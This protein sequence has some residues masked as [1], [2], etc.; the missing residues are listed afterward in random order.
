MFHDSDLSEEQTMIRRFVTQLA[1]TYTN[2]Y[3]LEHSRDVQFPATF[4]TT[5]AD[6]GFFGL[7]AS[8]AAGGSGFGPAELAVFLHDMAAAGLASYHLLGQLLA[9]HLLHAHGS[10]AQRQTQLAQLVAGVRWGVAMVDDPRGRSLDAASVTATNA[11]ADVRLSGRLAFVPCAPDL[12]AL[13]VPATADGEPALY[14]L[15]PK[16][17]GVEATQR[18]ISVRVIE[19]REPQRITGDVFYDLELKQVA[20][21]PLGKA[22]AEAYA[23]A[24][25]RSLLM[26]AATASGWGARAIDQGVAYAN[27]RILYT[28]PIAAYQAIQHP[29]VRAK[30]QVEMAN[31]LIER[32]VQAWI[33]A[34]DP[35]TCQTYAAVAKY[36]AVEGAVA[37]FDIAMQ[38][39][40]GS[41]F[42][43]ETGLI[44]VW[45][46]VLM[47]R[48]MLLNR[49]VVLEDLGRQ[50]L[51]AG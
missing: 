5:L 34:A 17:A 49:D 40:G 1:R 12:D 19:A 26:L 27:E 15:D 10:N 33:D 23:G 37:A 44:T 6:N 21:E 9:A 4:W 42:D 16:A 46:L 7:E 2:D 31:L 47:A 39:H 30:T 3:F 20:A 38:A 13:I 51:A 50:V 35:H 48:P 41:S 43:R 18:H 45:P 32:A 22:G 25:G 28:E 14:V 36:A 24:V 8:E 11:G 29:M